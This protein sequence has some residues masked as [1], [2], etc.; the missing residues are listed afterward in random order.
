[1]SGDAAAVVHRQQVPRV[2]VVVGLDVRR[3]GRPV[4]RLGQAY[5]ALVVWRVGHWLAAGLA[6]V[7]ATGRPD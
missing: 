3:H 5:T 1:M 2:V 4:A 7:L 6:E